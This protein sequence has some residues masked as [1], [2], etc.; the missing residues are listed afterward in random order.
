MISSFSLALGSGIIGCM[1]KIDAVIFDV[2]GVLHESNPIAAN[3]LAKQLNLSKKTLGQ[4]WENK[5]PL[6]ACKV[7]H[8]FILSSG[9]Y[10]QVKAL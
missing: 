9:E 6:L 1:N 4:I 5:I 3:S 7:C 8:L 10:E 2:G